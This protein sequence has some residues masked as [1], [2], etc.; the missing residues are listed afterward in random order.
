M[1]LITGSSRNLGA[2]IAKRL[3]KEGHDVII[4]AYKAQKEAQQVA[5]ECKSLGVKAEVFMGDLF[6]IDAFLE[7]FAK[8]GFEVKGLV[9]N[10][11][12]YLHNAPS[13]FSDSLKW[14]LPVNLLAPIA[15]TEALLPSIKKHKGSIVN[16]GCAG[17]HHV[18]TRACAYG[19]TKQALLHYSQS[20][21]KQMAPYNVT[22]NM[23][24]PGHLPYSSDLP[25]K[26]PMNKPVEENEIASL[27]AYL[28]SQSACSITGQ[29]IEVAGAVSL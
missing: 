15:L 9:N 17:L 12:L 5:L 27:I 24:S 21:A 20:L 29:N 18:W 10:V 19:L 28:F 2:F 1:I 3:A 6:N 22:V 7:A 23:V 11:G 26:L 14:L 25:D 8:K 13:H 4:H 16:L